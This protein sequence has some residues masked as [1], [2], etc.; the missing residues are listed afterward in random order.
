M[1]PC[2]QRARAGTRTGWCFQD[3]YQ[4]VCKAA[5]N[6]GSGALSWGWGRVTLTNKS[7]PEAQSLPL[8][9]LRRDIGS[10]GRH[11]GRVEF[12]TLSA[13]SPHSL[14]SPCAW[15]LRRSCG[16]RPL[17]RCPSGAQ[18]TLSTQTWPGSSPGSRVQGWAFVSWEGTPELGGPGKSIR[19][20]RVWAG[21]ELGD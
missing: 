17:P 2:E 12:P 8:C 15:L 5:L 1:G 21:L 18:A 19:P 6:L 20:I 3:P 13:D 7:R 11:I 14:P 4:A 10:Q 9:V 16:L